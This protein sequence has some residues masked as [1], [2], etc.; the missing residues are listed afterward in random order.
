MTSKFKEKIRKEKDGAKR[1]AEERDR[2]K[3]DLEGTLGK[4]KETTEEPE[5]S[6][7][8]SKVQGELET[9]SAERD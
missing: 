2:L 9:A 6:T 4:S 7:A 1:I 8:L 3:A 5:M